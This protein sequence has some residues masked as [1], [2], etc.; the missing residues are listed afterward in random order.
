MPQT[1]PDVSYF[2]NC[3]F[4]NHSLFVGVVFWISEDLLAPCIPTL[5]PVTESNK[6]SEHML[7]V[8]SVASNRPRLS[9]DSSS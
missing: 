3:Y 9:L 8:S 2:N 5:Q 1:E 7:C 4:F 6:T